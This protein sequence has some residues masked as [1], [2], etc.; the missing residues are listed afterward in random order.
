LR[1]QQAFY[2]WFAGGEISVDFGFTKDFSG[3]KVKFV[4]I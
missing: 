4:K 2:C 3:N 1:N